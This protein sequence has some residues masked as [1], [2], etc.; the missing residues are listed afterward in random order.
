MKI[1]ISVNPYGRTYGRY[2]EGKFLKIKQHGYDAVDYNIADTNSE[3][4]SA[5]KNE[6]KSIVNAQKCAAQ[7]AGIQISQV[8]GPWQWPPKDSSPQYREERLDKMKK[9]VVITSL[10]GCSNLVIH[11]IMPNGIEDLKNGKQRETWDLNVEFF[12]SLIDFAKQYGITI[13]LENMPMRDFSIATPEKILELVKEINDDNF[14]IC[15]DTGHV[16]IFPQLSVG[17]EIRKLGD[18]IKVLHIHDNMGDGDHHLYPT[19]GI[20]DWRD[21]VNALDEI[22]YEGVLSLETS[23]SE[24]LEND[25][26]EKES[27]YL[28]KMFK[29]LILANQKRNI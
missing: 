18:Y 8:H 16:S 15:L 29:E 9:S 11:P 6:L 26:F 24:N 22:G 20:I 3:L 7:S 17:N 19:K 1:G 27:I 12:K 13:C 14:K 25:V 21:F 28:C 23:P 4:Y 5:N 10:L 2:K